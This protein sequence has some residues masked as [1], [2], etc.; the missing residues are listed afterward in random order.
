MRAKTRG[1]CGAEPAPR[2]AARPDPSLRKERFA[3]DDSKF[4]HYQNPS[5]GGLHGAA[6]AAPLQKWNLSG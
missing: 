1:S 4:S 2:R 5:I 3:Q 6:L